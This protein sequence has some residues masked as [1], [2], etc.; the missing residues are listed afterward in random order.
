MTNDTEIGVYTDLLGSSPN[1]VE[2]EFSYH[3][4]ATFN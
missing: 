1:I 4:V 2:F 3:D